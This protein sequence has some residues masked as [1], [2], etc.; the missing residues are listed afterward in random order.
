MPDAIRATNLSFTYRY[1]SR[2]ALRSVSLSVAPA[3][4]VVLVGPSG[5]G[6]STLCY[7]MNGLVPRFLRG[8]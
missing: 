3:E 1:G 6:K 8:E 2:P 5:A 4:A 7:A